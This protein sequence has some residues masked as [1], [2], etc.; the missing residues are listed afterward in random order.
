MIK[1]LNCQ[2][3]YNPLKYNYCPFCA[4]KPQSIQLFK[5]TRV[6]FDEDAIQCL[7]FILKDNLKI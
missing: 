7:D 5:E 2:N 4:L 6:S 1:C 3:E